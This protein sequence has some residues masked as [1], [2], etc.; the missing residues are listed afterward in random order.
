MLAIYYITIR[1]NYHVPIFKNMVVAKIG[2]NPL[3]DV[4]PKAPLLKFLEITPGF[5]TYIFVQYQTKKDLKTHA[6]SLD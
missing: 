3:S 2:P 1:L 5:T 4:A 6:A